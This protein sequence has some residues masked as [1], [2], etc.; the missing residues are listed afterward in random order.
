[1]QKELKRN[2]II[3]L[4]ILAV[5]FG[6]IPFVTNASAVDGTVSGY[7]WSPRIGWINFGAFTGAD[8]IHVT[9]SGLTGFAW[10]E[11]KGR[12]NL[13][14]TK[15]GVKNTTGGV[16]SGYAWS[17]STGWINFEG[18]LINAHGVF[19]GTALGEN[20]TDIH[21]SC[22]TCEETTDWLPTTQ[23]F[24]TAG[25]SSAQRFGSPPTPASDN[26][27]PSD[28]DL[29][30]KEEIPSLAQESN[31]E[32]TSSLSSL[33]PIS[34]SEHREASVGINN[35]SASA[36]DMRFIF[37]KFP[38][39]KKVFEELGLS[40]N[41]N[42]NEIINAKVKLPG[43]A[44]FDKNSIPS[45]IVFAQTG[46]GSADL[47]A[48]ISVNDLGRV[49]Q[50][51]KTTVSEPLQLVVKVDKPVKEIRGYIILKPNK[52]KPVSFG[53]F[54]KFFNVA[55][56]ETNA[57]ANS[58]KNILQTFD[59]KY[60]SDGVYVADILAPANVGE[61]EI[62]TSVVYGDAA[63]KTKNLSLTAVV[64]PKGVTCETKLWIALVFLVI[65][66]LFLYFYRKKV[67]HMGSQ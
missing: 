65:I 18:V 33:S 15:S 35:I 9:S 1:M 40:E 24:E 36:E 6:F 57:E 5:I 61:Y 13:S 56:A 21:F 25:G 60:L 4:F 45:D 11:N 22:A 54:S 10:N 14:P 48:M 58:S 43:A 32:T 51:V 62:V 27:E 26:Q 37:Q 34:D 23:A 52:P 28:T 12:I 31:K 50:V 39:I 30:A 46:D 7:A 67:I 17:E 49:I 41:S 16:L 42:A 19:S 63:A 38:E 29:V 44:S 2:K 59:Y 64:G 55:L 53:N 66:E 47:N 8:A 3:K 20:N